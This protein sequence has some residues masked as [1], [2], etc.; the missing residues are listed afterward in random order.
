ML[1][2]VIVCAIIGIFSHGLIAYE[3]HKR[4]RIPYSL[5][6][7]L[8]ALYIAVAIEVITWELLI[9]IEIGGMA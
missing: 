8:L 4:T 6:L 5:K 7:S 2:R 1:F 9:G 3:I